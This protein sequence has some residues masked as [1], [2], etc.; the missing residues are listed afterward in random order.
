MTNVNYWD[1]PG[2]Y[3]ALVKREWKKFIE[4]GDIKGLSVRDEVL[5]SWKK[6]FENGLS[7]SESGAK[8]VLNE[9]D[10]AKLIVRNAMLIG[11]AQPVLDEFAD[12]LKKRGKTN[13]IINLCNEDTVIIRMLACGSMGEE[14][15]KCQS[16]LPGAILNEKHTGTTGV[17]MAKNSRSPYAVYGYEHYT[18]LAKTCN[19]AAVPIMNTWT[20]ELKGIFALSGDGLEISSDT[21]GMLTF[22]ARTI[23]SNY[24]FAYAEMLQT[25]LARFRDAVKRYDADLIFA[26]DT[27]LQVVASS[28]NQH[29]LLSNVLPNSRKLSPAVCKAAKKANLR[30]LFEQKTAENAIGVDEAD[31]YSLEFSPVYK[32]DDYIGLI[33]SAG[34]SAG[35]DLHAPVLNVKQSGGIVGENPAFLTALR[36][37]VKVAPSDASV[38]LFGETGVGKEV[39]ARMIYER[40]NRA[41]KAFVAV[42]CGA[43]PKE[44]IGSELFG[45]APGAFTGASPRG[46]TGKFEAAN[47]G[48]IFLD[49][50]EA[51]SF[52]AQT[53]LLRV[54]EEKELFRLGSNRSVPIDVRIICAANADLPELI[55]KKQF[56]ADLYFRLTVIQINIPPLRERFDDLAGLISRFSLLY[57]DADC[58]ISQEDLRHIQ[59]H[60]WPGNVRELKNVVYSASVLSL[61]VVQHLKDYVS[62]HAKPGRLP[63]ASAPL[64]EKEIAAEYLADVIRGCGGNIAGAARQLGLARSTIY[65]RLQKINGPSAGR[66]IPL[67]RK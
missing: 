21:M 59:K 13:N 30:F 58:S 12:L 29:P 4:T 34:R 5:R 26:A 2:K 16:I 42:N 53:Y 27:D 22:V 48:T 44:L 40:S 39:F 52:E 45:Y 23:E 38:V 10:M 37:A 25:L 50:L 60:S 56:R 32:G 14:D 61:D 67:N 9:K 47:G 35:A 54:L 18:Q 3:V 62:I 24:F 7:Y 66:A 43:F 51:L 15:A 36:T 49:E 20:K 46:N 11:A 65:R 57:T 64:P 55:E 33:V 41:N 63:G 17:S 1:E 8:L 19:C 28:K 6:S 31:G